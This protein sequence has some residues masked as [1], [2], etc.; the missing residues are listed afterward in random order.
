MT[1]TSSPISLCAGNRISNALMFQVDSFRNEATGKLDG[2]RRSGMGQFLTSASIA[3]LMASMF[4]ARPRTLRVLD[5]GAGVGSLCAAMVAEAC[6]W[7]ERPEEL[8]LLAY[9]IEPVLVEYLLRVLDL[10]GEACQRAGIRFVG[11]VRKED[12]IYAAVATSHGAEMFSSEHPRVNAAILNPPYRKIKSDSSERRLLSAVGIETSNLYTAFLWLTERMLESGGEM[13]AITPRSFCNGPYFRG[14]RKALTNT[15]KLRRLHVFASRE[16]A[17]SD[18]DVLQENIITHAVKS[19]EPHKVLITSSTGPDDED[20]TISEFE[21]DEVIDPLDGESFIHVVTD[22][23]EQRIAKCIGELTASLSDL[24]LTV[25]TGRVVDFRASQLLRAEPGANTVPLIYPTHLSDGAVRW[26]KANSK[27]SNAILQCE[28]SKDLLVPSGYYVLVKRFS[29]KEERRRVVAAVFDPQRFAHDQVAFE[30]HLNYYHRKGRGL[31]APLAKGLAAFLNSSLLDAYFRQFNGHTQVNATD[32]RALKYP[33][34]TNLISLGR[35]MS[36]TL[37]EQEELDCLV[38]EEILAMAGET[39][40]TRGKRMVEQALAI[41]GALQVPREQQNQRSALTLLSLLEMK[42]RASWSDADSPLRGITEMMEY[43][44]KHFGVR[45]APN[46]RETVRRYTIHQF[47]QLGIVVANPDNPDRPVN[48]PD[49]RYQI[50][51]AVLELIRTFDTPTWKKNLA[52]YLATAE[53]ITRLHPRERVMSQ[54]PVI[55]PDGKR[56]ELTSGGQNVLIKDILEEFCPR[57]TPGATVLYVGDA[58]AKFKVFEKAHLEQLNVT[59]DEH[60]KM[61]DVVVHYTEKNWLVL[62]EAVTS[63]GPVS[64]K[65]HNELKKLFKG[66]TP[67]LVFITAFEARKAMVKYLGDIAWET[68][69]WVAESPTHLIHFDGKRFLGP[70]SDR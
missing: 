28:E 41:L 33:P 35:R 50:E 34:A 14:F 63:H 2:D 4:S 26:P 55:L 56:I 30:N 57:Y 54:I 61:P 65:R 12:F 51:R 19:L 42:P 70:Y 13:V 62:I 40:P 8:H 58:G 47:V 9:E 22:E 11:E 44:Q 36:E 37:P 7:E 68:D 16:A 6:T 59:I 15:M 52:A 45:Y 24:D 23:T 39:S 46:T 21:H 60:G 5:A 1:R 20:C 25:S 29:A 53:A 43:F 66:A 27:K 69:V 38:C 64:L 49:N 10:C 31:P 32:L 17:F 48:S 3:R 18:D 67:A